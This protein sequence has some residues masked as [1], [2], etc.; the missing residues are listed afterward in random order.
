[1]Y[2]KYSLHALCNICVYTQY[3]YIYI[4]IHMNVLCTRMCIVQCTLFVHLAHCTLLLY[5]VYSVSIVYNVCI[6]CHAKHS[7]MCVCVFVCLFGYRLEVVWVW[8]V[9]GSM[10]QQRVQS[11]VLYSRYVCSAVFRYSTRFAKYAQLIHICL[12]RLTNICQ[13][14]TKVDKHGPFQK[15]MSKNKQTSFKMS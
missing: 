1:M 7:H 3:V 11:M 12:P 9:Q 5:S 10:I 13:L 4:Y 6:G 14:L 15:G 8:F 2:T